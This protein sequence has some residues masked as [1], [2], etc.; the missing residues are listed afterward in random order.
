MNQEA[1]KERIKSIGLITLFYALLFSIC[2]YKNLTGIATV[3]IAI[4]TVVFM[5]YYAAK[6]CSNEM[7]KAK[8]LLPYYIGILLLGISV[9]CTTDM[10]IICVNYIGML[11]LIFCALIRIFCRDKRWGFGKYFVVGLEMFFSPIV[12]LM[13][14]IRD[15]AELKKT[16]E[17]PEKRIAKYILIGVIISIP[18]LLLVMKLLTSADAVFS[19]FVNK[20]I[21]NIH[22]S[23]DIIFFTIL[24]VC[25]FLYVYGLAVKLSANNI[26]LGVRDMRNMEP[27]IGITVT[28]MLTFIYLI[29]S[30]I[31]ILFLFGS[32][33][34]LPDGY[35]YSEYARSGFFQL[36]FVGF[37][38]LLIVLF[39]VS[40]FRKHKVF[41]IV[42]TSMSLCTYIML[43][44]SLCR[45]LLYIK[46]FDL[47]YLRVLTL[48]GL[49]VIAVVMVGVII[50]IYRDG[51]PLVHYTIL[52]VGILWIA[53]S[54]CR[55]NYM[56]ARYN[57]DKIEG[58][59][60]VS[61]DPE[62]QKIYMDYW[63]LEY[64][65]S[66]GEDA[67][68]A[69]YDLTE[70]I[71]SGSIVIQ[72]R[73]NNLPYESGA[74]GLYQDYFSYIEEN[75]KND[76]DIRGFNFSRYQAYQYAEKYKGRYESANTEV[77]YN[78]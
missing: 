78:R 26:D 22:I 19:H 16:G 52:V 60:V 25:V 73:G 21:G 46:T 65:Y 68:P 64:L 77:V 29:F 76:A 4:A 70:D 35:T 10:F 67:A 38:N 57:I 42:L 12:Y 69:L 47:T 74:Q 6:I 8:R 11:L 44:S 17:K 18:F 31:Q 41:N 71:A 30:V 45:M 59:M 28:S 13:C 50:C 36:L 14:P 39:C 1:S 5:Y 48:F 23:N 33:M 3:I 20:A 61:G 32:G 9:C 27:V 49:A 53:F 37:L 62:S 55:P 72:N 34:K 66:L 7:G 40:F 54:F 2:L 51:F 58:N 15:F 43:V 56:I 75:W 24:M 63:D